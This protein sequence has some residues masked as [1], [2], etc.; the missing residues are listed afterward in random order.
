MNAIN[1][2]KELTEWAQKNKEILFLVGAGNRGA[3]LSKYLVDNDIYPQAVIDEA[4]TEWNIP[5]RLATY[6]VV[7]TK[8]CFLITTNVSIYRESMVNRLNNKGVK[9]NAIFTISDNVID[10][11][12]EQKY[13]VDKYV[14]RVK[15]FKNI[16]EGETCF[17]VGNGPSLNVR[18][19]DKIAQYTSF[20]LNYI[21]AMYEKTKWRATYYGTYDHNFPKLMWK[22]R[23]D[24]EKVLEMHKAVFVSSKVPQLF[25]YRDDDMENLYFL[26]FKSI[27]DYEGVPMK[28]DCSQE[29]IGG[30]TSIMPNIQLAMYMGFKTICLLGVDMG[31]RTEDN[32]TV[33]HNKEI[34]EVWKSQV[35]QNEINNNRGAFE[36]S[37]PLQVQF[38]EFLNKYA[39]NHDI[40]ILN[41]TRGGFLEVF[42]RIDLDKFLIGEE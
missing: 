36:K 18:D 38:F 3:I 23:S 34:E 13:D 30:A 9:N 20:G 42:P 41:A 28:I 31:T 8:G 22:E 14:S 24:I 17:I 25:D 32:N 2:L 39:L 26:R 12:Y 5:I 21:Y 33:Y 40:H 35:S 7:R 29:V 4:R 11:I 19:L 15:V 1:T 27:E 37:I 10:E 16:H 6:D